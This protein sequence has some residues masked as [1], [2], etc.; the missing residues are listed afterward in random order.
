MRDLG[1]GQKLP[2]KASSIKGMRDF[3]KTVGV[4]Y[5][6]AAFHLSDNRLFV[7]LFCLTPEEGVFWL[8]VT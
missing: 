8:I 1:Q 6:S 5:V 2:F 7:C 3:Y 4:C